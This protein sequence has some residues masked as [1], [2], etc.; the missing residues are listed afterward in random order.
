[1]NFT[2]RNTITTTGF[3]LLCFIILPIVIIV[4]PL[5]L[6]AAGSDPS[7]PPCTISGVSTV[8]FGETATFT[9]ACSIY[10]WTVG[11]ATE[12]SHTST[13]ITIIFNV[14]GCTSA[15]ID[16]SKPAGGNV[17][18]FTVTINPAQPLAG[19]SITG[20]TPTIPTINFGATILINASAA[21]GGSCS[22]AYSYQWYS[23]PDDINYAVISGSAAQAQNYQ[24]PALYMTTYF[25][26][27]VTCGTSVAYT[28]NTIGITVNG[29]STGVGAATNY[30]G[31]GNPNLNWVIATGY[32]PSGNIISQGKDFYDNSGMLLQAQSKVIY[33]RDENLVFTHVFASQP[34]YDVNG[35]PA[36]KTLS[37]PI[38]YADFNY[39]SNFAQA[40]D[41]SAYTYKNF[42]KIKPTT[43]ETDKTNSPD[44]IGSQSVKGTLGWYYGQNNTWEPYMPTTD[45]PYTRQTYYQD[46]TGNVK[47]SGGAGETFKMGANHESS[48]FLTP[49]ANELDNYLKIRNQFFTAAE[50]GEEPISLQSRA[51]QLIGK[52]AQGNEGIVIQDK[53]GKTLIT[54]RPGTEY[55]PPVN[56]LNVA[57][58]NTTAYSQRVS[59][60][61]G[62]GIS[63]QVINSQ[64]LINAYLIN[65][66]GVASYVYSGYAISFPYNTNIGS[67]ILIVESGDYFNMS[68]TSNGS[69]YN[70]INSAIITEQKIGSSVYFKILADNTPVTITGDYA[71]INME[72]E[73][74]TSVLSG[75]VLNKGYYKLY[76]NSYYASVSYANS[77]ADLS[78]NFYNQLGQLIASIAPEGVKKL[79]GTYSYTTKADLPF[80]TLYAYDVQGRLVSTTN[81]DGG[82]SQ[83]VYRADG[84]VRFSQNAT[85]NA[86][87]TG[88]FS[89]INYD[90]FGRPVEAGE[91]QPDANGIVF[92]S[93]AMTAILENT[94]SAGGLTTGVKRDV[95]VSVY[96]VPDNSYAPTGYIQ[97]PSDYIQDPAYLGN[98]ISTSLKYSSVT[99]NAPVSTN[100]VSQTWY[101]YD[102]EGKVVWQIK[103]MQNAGGGS[104]LYKTTDFTYDALGHLIKKVF[105]KNT[106]AE[107]FVHYYMYD[108][109]NQQLWKVYTN[110]TDAAINPLASSYMLQ[111]TYKYYLHGGLK[112]V[113]LANQLQGIDYT[114][115]LQGALKAINNNNRVNDPGGDGISNTFAQDAFGMVLDY[116]TDDYKNARATGILPINGVNTANDNYT[117][118]IKAM[119]WYSEKPS[120]PGLNDNPTVYTYKYDN[121]YQL[122]ESAWGTGL[123]FSATQGVPATFTPA[124]INSEKVLDPVSGAPGYDANGNI[125]YLQRTDPNG[126]LQDK[127]GYNYS[128]N[129]NQL[130]SVVNTASGSSNTYASY[131]YN[132][133]GQLI[134]ETNTDPNKTKYIQYDVSGKVVAVFKNNFALI[135]VRY[136][137]DETGKR[138]Q[139]ILYNPTNQSVTQVT[140]YFDDVIF[141]QDVANA[142]SPVAQEYDINGGNGRI[143]VFYKQSAVYAYQMTDHLG[144]VRAVIA[145]SGATFTVRM[146]TDYYPFGMEIAKGGTN[147]YRHGYQGSYSEKD[148]E[149]DWNSF[150]LRM[151]DSRIAR[152]QQYDPK[153]QFYSPYVGMG[154]NPVSGVDPDGGSWI[155]AVHAWLFSKFSGGTY[156]TSN[157]KKDGKSYYT[158]YYHNPYSDDD[159]SLKRWENTGY[160]FVFDIQVKGTVGPQLGLSGTALGLKGKAEG[161]AWTSDIGTIGYDFA[162]RKNLSGWDKDHKMHNFGG[163]EVEWN[164]KLK[165][166]VKG[167][168][169]Y[170]YDNSEYG[171]PTKID[172][173]E[174]GGW[175][176]YIVDQKIKG[177]DVQLVENVIKTTMKSTIAVSDKGD[178]TF[179]GLELGGSLK[180]LLGGEGKVRFGL[181]YESTLFR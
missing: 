131:T 140:Y 29:P 64:N 73:Q 51:I 43:S 133:A 127:F 83:M 16:G 39:S 71:L 155:D 144:N 87:G 107:T 6:K 180:A 125:L 57:A 76:A 77:Y 3:N 90:L 141:T 118:N 26:R 99:N 168:Y 58:G 115:T 82:S 53:A 37:A 123:G 135:L 54:G 165:T 142:G 170:K 164:E 48:S 70:N 42:D 136:V 86:S 47:K 88:K 32:D 145:Q 97:N 167:D 96:D 120:I 178:G 149:T 33:R 174:S 36:A 35:R 173:S 109:A 24:T 5:Q 80:I 110:T 1:M 139:K 177:S 17:P 137:Y 31:T 28:S 154:N 151:Y 103:M 181:Q 176:F 93:P 105:Q 67:G 85:Q 171:L 114:Y 41:G 14:P 20:T 172:G 130:Q 126:V 162:N 94:T 147:D 2:I 34:L 161:G 98:G 143:G 89:Y 148:G 69:Q 108:P 66:A 158:V 116:Y 134:T 25:K 128:T 30:S 49:V 65:A 61:T 46:G 119:S 163:L 75:S 22:L 112:R 18:T 159:I 11:C 45:F 81:P 121:K 179:L 27:M 113:E 124:T 138:I 10:A 111:A 104:P 21:T 38:D 44:Q 132:E 106:A 129:K 152:W 8:N 4:A 156:G 157:D 100:L 9:S 7:S 117:G 150:E 59:T 78:Y 160:K 72:T 169:T 13:T 50:L 102:E 63:V 92:N 40:A 60:V 84:K 153:G 175:G 95:I 62:T 166:G 146:Y 55:T 74:S 122:T 56:T 15:T 52:D 19:G 12:V 101:N 68:Y 79:Y 91:Y 23:S